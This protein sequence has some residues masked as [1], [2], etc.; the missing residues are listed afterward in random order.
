MDSVSSL[1]SPNWLKHFTTVMFTEVGPFE[2][3]IASGIPYS[4]DP[5][6]YSL[7]CNYKEGVCLKIATFSISVVCVFYLFHVFILCTAS[8]L[9]F[10]Q[11][12]TPIYIC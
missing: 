6:L 12:G 10:I 7:S 3:H 1:S 8:V 9:E 2:F 4:L 11:F 5:A